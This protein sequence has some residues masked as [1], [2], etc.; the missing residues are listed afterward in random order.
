MAIE[1]KIQSASLD[2][3]PYTCPNCGTAAFTLDGSGL[4]DRF[5]AWGNCANYHS[6]EDPLI[7]RGDLRAILAASTGR[8][9]AEDE[10]RF[11]VE[12]GGAILA[13]I[14]QPELTADDIRQAVKRVYWQRLLKPA[15]RRQKRAAIRAVK[16]PAKNA[17][18][19]AKAA[20]LT[21]AWDLQTGGHQT[22]PDHTPGPIN[23][24]PFCDG[25]LIELDSHLHDTT[26]RCTVCSGTGE[27][28]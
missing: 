2:G 11:A 14:L 23:A 22:D 16:R 17:V 9:R 24:C 6:W 13:G 3:T 15:L 18:A 12:I 4:T 27:L 1:V 25:G 10:D 8:Q 19:A 26:V 28:D 20:A 5:P 7:T 21:A